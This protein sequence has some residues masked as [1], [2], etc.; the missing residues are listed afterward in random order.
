MG[1]GV[2]CGTGASR[3]TLT[4]A[5]SALSA[6]AWSATVIGSV[7]AQP[8]VLARWAADGGDAVIVCTLFGWV[9]MVGVKGPLGALRPTR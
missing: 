6:Q 1:C 3:H 4:H 2:S 8:L 5:R 7:L 9:T